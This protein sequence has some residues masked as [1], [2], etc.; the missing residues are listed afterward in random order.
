[1][2]ENLK[3]VTIRLSE[4][5]TIPG[6]QRPYRRSTESAVTLVADSYGAFVNKVSEYRIGSVVLHREV[7]DNK[8]VKLNVVDG[9][10][11]LTTISIM[12]FVFCEIIKDA[13]YENMSKLL[14][15]KYNELEFPDIKSN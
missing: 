3:I 9:Q 1:M 8:T 4:N 11:R 7:N 10:Q 15:E 6:Y 14:V 13:G 5:L 12:F 2:K